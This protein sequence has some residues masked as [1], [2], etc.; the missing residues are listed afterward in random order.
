[1]EYKQMLKYTI[2]VYTY[3]INTIFVSTKKCCTHEN[4]T[5]FKKHY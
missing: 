4:R 3:K 1:M 5:S 2:F